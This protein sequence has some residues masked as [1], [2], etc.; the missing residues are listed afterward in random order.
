MEE[1]GWIRDS[2]QR[3]FESAET[4]LHIPSEHLGAYDPNLS[5]INCKTSVSFVFPK[6]QVAK[7][8]PE[9]SLGPGCRHLSDYTRVLCLGRIKAF[10]VQFSHSVVSNCLRPH[11]LQHTRP[12]C[13]SLIP[14]FTQTLVHR[15]GD[16]M[17]PSHPLSSPSP[18]APNLSQHQGLFK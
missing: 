6:G 4:R 10:L 17:Q 3:K 9:T 7:V 13:P 2:S 16:T 1:T 5:F 14:E 11:G 18:P 8:D 15:V 12:P